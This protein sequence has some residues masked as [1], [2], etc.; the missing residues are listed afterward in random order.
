M[1]PQQLILRAAAWIGFLAI[2]FVTLS[3]VALRPHIFASS[4]LDR[5]AAFAALGFLL[6]AAYPRR[7][8]L[9]LAVVLGGAAGLELLQFI[10]P[11]RDARLIDFVAKTVGGLIGILAARW[12][13]SLSGPPRIVSQDKA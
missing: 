1:K 9:V 2:C 11:D 10:T 6:Q 5:F 7:P 12:L 13:P 3:P 8:L 4:A